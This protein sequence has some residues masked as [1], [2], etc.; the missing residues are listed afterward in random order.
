[1]K[2]NKSYK[3]FDCLGHELHP[4]DNVKFN[5]CGITVIGTIKSI[6]NNSEDNNKPIQLSLFGPAPKITKKPKKDKYIISPIGYYGGPEL[7]N[8]IKKQYKV[9]VDAMHIFLVT[10]TWK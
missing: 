4:G 3:Y 6:E 1:M 10:V 7:K 9:N 8:K 2:A 5:S